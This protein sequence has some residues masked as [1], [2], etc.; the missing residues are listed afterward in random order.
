MQKSWRLG[1]PPWNIVYCLHGCSTPTS[2]LEGMHFCPL[3][4]SHSEH[5]HLKKPSAV[6]LR[7][8]PQFPAARTQE[9]KDPS[10]LFSTSFTERSE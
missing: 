9:E 8:D 7:V 6:V 10:A 2:A 1:S 5:V 4:R 3:S